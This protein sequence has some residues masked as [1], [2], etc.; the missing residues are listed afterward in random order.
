[1][2]ELFQI[3]I[4]I[5][6]VSLISLIGIV[7]LLTKRKLNKVLT[8]LIAFAAGTMLATAFFHM[9]PE[10]FIEINTLWPVLAGIIFFFMIES[11]IHW[12]HSHETEC[13]SCINPMAYLNLIGDGIHN[14]LDGLII[15]ASFLVDFKTGLIV[16]V[17]IML[18]EIPQEIGDFAILLHSGFSKIKALLLNLASALIAVIGGVVGYFFFTNLEFTLPYVIAIAAG[19]FIYIAGVDIFPELHK[20][21]GKI[22]RIIQTIA[23]IIGV[24]MIYIISA[25]SH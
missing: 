16:T 13:E 25:L 6:L 15:A 4:A 8:F 9:I 18:H 5:I 12:H 14:F 11:L 19:G 23:L 17:S 22:K 24:L 2:Q 21:K 20:E 3:I 1:M 7:F 10:S